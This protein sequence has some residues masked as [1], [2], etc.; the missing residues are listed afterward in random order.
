MT[1]NRSARL[2]GNLL[3]LLTALIWGI[4]FVAQKSGGEELG[5][6]TFNGLRSLIGAAALGAALPLLDKLGLSHP[7]AD[8]A[9]RKTLWIGGIICG[10]ALFAATNL[11]QL[12]ILY[13]NVGKS[14]FITALY[15]VLVP[16]IGI[17]LGNKVT[18][19]NWIGVVI[20]VAGLYLLC[21]VGITDGINRG[22]LLLLGC[23]LLFSVQ[24]LAVS[25]FSPLVDGVRLSC[26]QFLVVGI[27]NLPLQLWREQFSVA[28]LL[29]GWL[30][31]LYAGV[32]S[33]GVAYT[34]QIIGQKYTEPTTASLLMS[35][36][37]VFAALSGWLILRDRMSLPELC[38]CILVFA[39]VVLSQLPVPQ[40]RKES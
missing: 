5:P 15:I 35:L 3:L 7:P 20:A 30:P 9:Q 23:A 25:R 22:D 18:W 11:Q 39:A 4:A 19:L 40:R 36:E 31:L 38:G 32:L 28:A 33:S 17:F 1:D 27:L 37:S 16:F 10:L 26:I 2:R 12:G 29:N 14:G 8:R 34:L 6:L 24:I 13:T 21:G